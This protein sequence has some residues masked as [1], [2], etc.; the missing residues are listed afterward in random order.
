MVTPH[1]GQHAIFKSNIAHNETVAVP[2][3][4]ARLAMTGNSESATAHLSAHCYFRS[5]PLVARLKQMRQRFFLLETPHARL[6]R[7]RF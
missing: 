4:A 2:I 1:K 7:P 3:L 6:L 5:I